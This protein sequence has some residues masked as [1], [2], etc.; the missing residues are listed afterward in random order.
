MKLNACSDPFVI[1][2]RST[3]TPWRSAIQVRNGR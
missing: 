1:I 3:S 2:T